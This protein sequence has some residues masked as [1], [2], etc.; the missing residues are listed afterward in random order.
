MR[1]NSKGLQKFTDFESL[2]TVENFTEFKKNYPDDYEQSINWITE[3]INE[4]IRENKE[5]DKYFN[6][7]E[8]A[9]SLLELDDNKIKIAKRERWR[10][11]EGKIKNCIHL[12]ITQ[13]GSLPSVTEIS[14]NTGLSRVTIS[15][16]LTENNLSEFKNEQMESFKILN[17][18]VLQMIYRI[19][20]KNNDVKALKIFFQLTGGNIQ[21]ETVINNNYIQVNNTKI[22]NAIINQLPN[23]SREAIEKIIIENTAVQK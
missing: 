2:K 18:N 13:S 7:I 16:H 5:I 12:E 19:G 4:A 11:N 8:N 20:M 1:K 22:N 6:R 21:T 15:K 14:E 17:T 3:K 10:V 9:L 23:E